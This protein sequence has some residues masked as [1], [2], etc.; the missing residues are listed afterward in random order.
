MLSLGGPRPQAL[1]AG[2]G[3]GAGCGEQMGAQALE[4][5]SLG[6]EPGLF[7]ASCVAVDRLLKPSVPQLPVC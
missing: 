4:P 2:A 6:S 1:G 7:L 5:G 3:D